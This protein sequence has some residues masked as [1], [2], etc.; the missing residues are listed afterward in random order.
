MWHFPIIPAGKSPE[1]NLRWHLQKIL[2]A[3]FEIKPLNFRPLK[4]VRHAVTYRAITVLPFHIQLAQLP[5]V[6][7]AKKVGLGDLSSLPI[8]NLTRKIAAA[9]SAQ[10]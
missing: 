6:P 1:R 4:K 9:A 10:R 7:G 8:S 3:T 2:G 5:T